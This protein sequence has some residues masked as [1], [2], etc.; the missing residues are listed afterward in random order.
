MLSHIIAFAKVDIFDTWR[1]VVFVLDA[2]VSMF[3]GKEK[4]GSKAET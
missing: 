3:C 1:F 2:Y 4:Q